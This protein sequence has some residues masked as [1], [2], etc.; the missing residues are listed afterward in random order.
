MPK[1][2]KKRP[3]KKKTVQEP[4]VRNFAMKTLEEMKMRQ[5]QFI[6]GGSAVAGVILLFIIISLYSSSQREKAYGY[7][8]EASN[9]YYSLDRSSA[10]AVEERTKK[11]IDLFRQSINTKATPTALYL[12]GNSYFRLG[13]YQN[14]IKEYDQFI[15]KFS[16]EKAILPLVYQKLA[17]AYFKSTQADNALQALHS[18]SIIDSGI[19]KDTAL[20]MEARYY[21]SAGEADKAMGIYKEIA[22][23]FPASPW[24]AESNAKISA[25]ESAASEAP[26]S[27]KS[28]AAPE[29]KE[30]IPP[31]DTEGQ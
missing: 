18:L 13:D 19:Y 26:D 16:G 23:D 21:D 31:S 8:V 9:L 20:I 11:A 28:E 5:R 15:K 25:A 29:E 30:G 27:E 17:S 12:L 1:V 24:A 7:A 14:A 3:A 2:I 10:Q 4:E 6:I 22:E